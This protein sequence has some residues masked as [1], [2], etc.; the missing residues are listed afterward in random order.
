MKSILLDTN[1]YSALVNGDSHVLAI[2]R[3]ATSI[4][5]PLIVVAELRAGFKKGSKIQENEVI[6][7][8]FLT[9]SIVVI[10]DLE[11][12]QYYARVYGHL[13]S[14]GRLIPTND[15]W[16]AALALQHRLTLLTFDSHFREV[17]SIRV[18]QTIEEFLDV[19]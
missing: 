9:K 6:L 19:T 7:S 4:Q 18:V 5:I 10:P 3:I 15:I 12:T 16:I 17:E 1:A 13:Q 11:T 8:A 14:K 2:L